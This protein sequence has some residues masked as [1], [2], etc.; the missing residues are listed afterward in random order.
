LVKWLGYPDSENT[1]EAKKDIDPGIVAAFEAH[2]STAHRQ[3]RTT[4]NSSSSGWSKGRS[5]GLEGA[6]ESN[7]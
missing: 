5:V 7:T 3:T 2:S 6:G 1:W 4:T